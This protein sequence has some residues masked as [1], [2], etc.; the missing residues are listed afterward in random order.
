MFT[1]VN[2]N[3]LKQKSGSS[4]LFYYSKEILLLLL[5]LQTAKL[6]AVVF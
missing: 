5:R 3:T 2:V 4:P 6:G 1:A